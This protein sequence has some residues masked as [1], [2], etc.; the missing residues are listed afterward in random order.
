MAEQPQSRIYG[1]LRTLKREAERFKDMMNISDEELRLAGSNTRALNDSSVYA[2]KHTPENV[3]KA[4]V[5]RRFS[6]Y[7]F[8][9]E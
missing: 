4:I 1:R 2:S 6:P 9:E 8:S 5:S 7:G 3:K